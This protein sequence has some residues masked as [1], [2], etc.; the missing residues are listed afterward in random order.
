MENKARYTLVGVFIIV[1]TACAVGFI[2][3][4]AKYDK[5]SLS[6]KEYRVYATSSVSGL[7]VNTIVLY[8]GLDIGFIEDIRINPSNQEE[9]EIVL[10]IKKP[11]IIKTDTSATIESLGITGNK[12]IEIK[13]GSNESEHLSFKEKDYAIIPL[14]KSFFDKITNDASSITQKINSVLNRVEFILN[15]KNIKN[16]NKIL[17]NTSNTSENFNTLIVQIQDFININA[18]NSLNNIDKLMNDNLKNSLSNIDVLVNDKITHSLG[19]IDTL[20]SN[21]NNLLQNDIKVILD[22]FKHIINASK[23]IDDVIIG[24]EQT[25]EKIDT[26]LD[27]F[28]QN[29]GDFLLKTRSIKYG[30]GEK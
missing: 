29:G 15:D 5:D 21:F 22:D 18:K 26:T 9:I 19:N 28:N 8:K 23:G 25:L 10:K 1:F 24:V 16:I 27:N 14:K 4:L 17:D 7:N 6:A 12:Y 11:E 2:L 13:G 30:P 20:S 3:W